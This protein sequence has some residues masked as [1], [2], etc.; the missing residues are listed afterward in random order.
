MSRIA[1]K[2]HV[3]VFLTFA[4]PITLIALRT[5]NANEP[6]AGV[7]IGCFGVIAV[8]F[9]Q[10]TRACQNRVTGEPSVKLQRDEA[11]LLF[12]LIDDVA[13]HFDDLVVHEV[14]MI[15]DFNAYAYSHRSL[16]P[17]FYRLTHQLRIG[18]SLLHG[19][20]VEELRG[21]IA[22]E[23]YHLSSKQSSSAIW[24]SSATMTSWLA[25]H[26]RIPFFNHWM[27]SLHQRLWALSIVISKREE[28]LAD[29]A[30]MDSV[31]A[32][33]IA[34]NFIRSQMLHSLFMDKCPQMQPSY[35]LQEKTPPDDLIDAFHNWFT[36]AL[37]D[38]QLAKSTY[39]NE[40]KRV[41]S[42]LEIHPSLKS[43]LEALNQLPETFDNETYQSV[44]NL[45]PLAVKLLGENRDEITDRVFQLAR[46]TVESKWEHY[47][48][49]Y[50][51]L[52]EYLERKHTVEN[53]ND[54]DTALSKVETLLA[55]YH[56]SLAFDGNK[57]AAPWLEKILTLK[58]DHDFAKVELATSQ[59]CS[60]NTS[61]IKVL[62]STLSEFNDSVLVSKALEALAAHYEKTGDTNK[63]FNVDKNRDRLR[64]WQ[65]ELERE[66]KRLNFAT[67]T[68]PRV[69]YSLRDHFRQTLSSE[70]SI[71]SVYI[72]RVQLSCPSTRHYIFVVTFP[73]FFLRYKSVLTR[74]ES[75]IGLDQ[76]TFS[77]V[78]S[79]SILAARRTKKLAGTRIYDALLDSPHHSGEQKDSTK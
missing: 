35:R 36:D 64:A 33:S 18:I 10:I 38:R 73:L 34:I 24:I 6:F 19:A 20:T 77:F 9:I 51:A 52:K 76:A 55:N 27:R 66:K 30:A 29:Q 7:M 75:K 11:P 39:T 67:L 78:S 71:R 8:A 69:P 2:V 59:L 26:F 45:T 32:K 23:M 5:F 49:H 61:G 60:G 43:R 79:T 54:G 15:D 48:R 56:L 13:K 58:P 70:P 21:I 63:L 12:E 62:E 72:A 14:L 22:H 3:T 40:L 17:G 4:I 65:E 41:F 1:L 46:K 31:G 37:Q 68:A 28:L 25:S 50:H 57:K 44:A 16:A 42:S 74:L 53:S 47:F